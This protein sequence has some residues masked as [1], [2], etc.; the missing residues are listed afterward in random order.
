MMRAVRINAFGGPDQVQLTDI[1][2]P[3]P[4]PGEALVR[5]H[6]AALNP[7]DW[8][9]REHIFNPPGSDQ[10]PLTLGEDFAGVIAGLG[11]GAPPTL[12]VGDEVLGE[13]LGSFADY[14]AAPAR[15]L[16]VKPAGLDFVTAAA[17]PMPSLTAW[18]AIVGTARATAGTRV[19]IHGAG[20]GV[21][22]FA[23]QFA[24]LKGAEVI[25]TTSAP[26]FAWLHQLGADC[27]IDYQE[28]R[29]EELARDV[30][31]VLDPKGGELQSRSL[32]VMRRGGLL[33]N[34]VGQVDAVAAA[35]AGVRAATLRM[36][37][38]VD[39][40]RHIVG[41]VEQGLVKPHVAHVLGLDD[42]PTAMEL[43]RHNQSHG[44]IVLAVA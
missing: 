34:L 35:R 30:D 43:N 37:F 13:H 31:V 20:G 3:R 42:A 19:L 39:E 29:F 21:G 41:L 18:Q 38:R 22:S 36:H 10:V 12:A 40:L 8:M 27:I 44:Q 11:P 17:L 2:E 33:I 16:V 5:V 6:A 28:Q 14:V 26:N 25:A 15:E 23:V 32:K 1:A 4:G 7:I 24:K 9:I